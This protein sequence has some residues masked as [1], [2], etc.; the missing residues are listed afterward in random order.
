L[1]LSIPTEAVWG[2]RMLSTGDGFEKLVNGGHPP[3]LSRHI[4]ELCARISSG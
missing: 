3:E 1:L 2:L 4:S